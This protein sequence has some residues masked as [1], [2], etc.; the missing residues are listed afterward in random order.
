VLLRARTTFGGLVEGECG[1]RIRSRMLGIGPSQGTALDGG[2]M[3]KYSPVMNSVT[4]RSG[5]IGMI[6]VPRNQ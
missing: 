2:R 6:V 3:M 5:G 4:N 1:K